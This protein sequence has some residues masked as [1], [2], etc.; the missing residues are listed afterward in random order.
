MGASLRAFFLAVVAAAI[1]LASGASVSFA[2]VQEADDR[3]VVERWTTGDG[4]PQNSITDI[5]QDE[6]GY[7]W[8]TTFGG[9]ARYD[10]TG[11]DVF[12]LQVDGEVDAARLVKVRGT[13][14]GLL[15][16][17]ES[18]QLVRFVG[19][20]FVPAGEA[21]GI[22]E[23]MPEFDEE[24][25]GN[26]LASEVDPQGVTWSLTGAGLVRG[27]DPPE[28]VFDSLETSFAGAI[29]FD[30]EADRMWF[31]RG[32]RLL[33][34][35]GAGPF[36]EVKLPGHDAR[37]GIRSLLVDREGALWVGTDGGGLLQVRDRRIVRYGAGHGLW[38]PSVR[39]VLEGS[40][41]RL[42]I[43]AGC[44]W[45]HWMDDDGFSGAE[46]PSPQA[47]CVRALAEDPSGDLWF[48]AD[49]RLYHRDALGHLSY[50]SGDQ[51]LDSDVLALLSEPSDG[52]LVATSKHG[53]LRFA[54]G[55]FEPLAGAEELRGE[56]VHVLRRA[57]DGALW[58]GTPHGVARISD[59]GVR[60]WGAADGLS[61]GVVRDV[62]LDADGTAWV[63]TYGGG[64][65]RI[66]EGDVRR[67][68]RA[69]GLCDDVVSRVLDGGDDALWMN[70]NRGVFRVPRVAF[71]RVAAGERDLLPCALLESGEGNGGAQPAG[72]R[73]RDGR[74]WFPTID[75]VAVVDPGHF[76][77]TPVPP[78]VSIER[79]SLDGR[80][81]SDGIAFG[82]GRGDLV[83]EY[84]GLA[85]AAPGE[86]V[87]RHRLA[88]SDGQWVTSGPGR[89][90]RYMGLPP[91]DYR[92][93]LQARNTYGEQS[94][95][96]T[97]SFSMARRLHQ[98]SWFPML[99][100]ALLIG[101][102]SGGWS[103]RLGA[104]E[105]Q[106]TRLQSEIDARTALAEQLRQAQ[107]VEVLGQLA[108][109]VA[110]DFNN[111]LMTVGGMA[112]LLQ[113]QLDE[114]KASMAGEILAAADR[115]AK[116]ASRLLE[117]SRGRGVQLEPL[118]PGE[119]VE[120]LLPM[121]RRL[122]SDRIEIELESVD[123]KPHALLD[124]V[125]LEQAVMNLVVNARDAMDGT[126]RIALSVGRKVVKVGEA[127][128]R[129]V[130]Q[131]D[132]VV[133]SV[134]DEGTGID[135]EVRRRLFEPFF[136]TKEPGTGTGLGLMSVHRVAKQAGGFVSVDSVKGEGSVFQLWLPEV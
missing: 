97:L 49:K 65:S 11:F 62:L 58:A 45:L 42:W 8:L 133:L 27:L 22:R 61:P 111:V 90:T 21:Q 120:D 15:L 80:P 134:S 125:E 69:E 88:G 20:R 14:E 122:A 39:T 26:T 103:L 4:L 79:A 9:L 60:R 68:T 131:G 53:V 28:L 16:T 124:R 70:G 41:G 123:V 93:E 47:G 67:F 115:G 73:A 1:G 91:G 7:L 87:F 82:P 24:E 29:L 109:G 35:E 64:L 128:A 6:D 101:L 113:E 104:A 81:L 51:G 71:D 89:V 37:Y 135:E 78:L 50:W 102:V 92:F 63:G 100:L 59:E 66:R 13:D 114:P 118:A 95:V 129:G 5:F 76:D 112:E 46:L 33:L 40:D 38:D 130:P 106:A 34:R 18:R 74:L 127:R 57:P 52:W 110:H 3:F 25:L 105:R 31:S 23:P 117:F 126:G 32:G 75:G 132:Y 30:V 98:T 55:R 56:A 86:L 136:T 54:D 85:L 36:V 77:F 44:G 2:Q 121:L 43:G 119:V 83:V 12:D 17:T 84:A 107:R 99:V 72:W 94:E 19:G 10:G 96:A 48:G 108:G 116:L